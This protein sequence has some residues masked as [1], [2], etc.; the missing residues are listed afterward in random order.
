MRAQEIL[1][2]L[3]LRLENDAVVE[4]AEA[5]YQTFVIIA[6]RLEEMAQNK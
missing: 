2:Q 3:K 6:R 5:L 1:A 4:R